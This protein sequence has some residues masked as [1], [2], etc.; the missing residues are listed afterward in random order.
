MMGF[1][2]RRRILRAA[3]PDDIMAGDFVTQGGLG[4]AGVVESVD[5]D[6]VT[7]AW[8]KDRRDIL[9]ITT[10]RRAPQRGSIFDSR[11]GK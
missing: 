1:S 2:R 5:G 7:V 11:S 6:H 9:P 10:L 3:E 8:D 4:P